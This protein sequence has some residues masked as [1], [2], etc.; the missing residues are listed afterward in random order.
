MNREIYLAHDNRPLVIIVDE[1]D[2]VRSLPFS[3]GEFFAAIRECYQRRVHD[4]RYERL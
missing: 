1:I 2:F 3:V 4:S